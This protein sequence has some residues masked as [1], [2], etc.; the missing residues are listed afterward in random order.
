MESRHGAYGAR[1][2]AIMIFRPILAA[3][4]AAFLIAAPAWAKDDLVIGVSQFPS[5]MHPNLDP[6]LV[7]GYFEAFA[8]HPVTAFDKDWKNSCLLCS[9]LPTLDNG[10]VK[11]EDRAG[12]G[13]G[14]AVTVKL[15]PDL[16]WGD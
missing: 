15:K 14:M 12:G 1:K 5:S 11:I 16:K 13:K 9:Q 4:C 3:A 6:E 2:G 10:L 8:L 7:K